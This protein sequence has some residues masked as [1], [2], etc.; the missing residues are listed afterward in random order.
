MLVDIH[1]HSLT[2]DPDVKEV[3]C[4]DP[5]IP[6][7]LSLGGVARFSFGFHPWLVN[8]M[9]DSFYKTQLRTAMQAPGFF[10]LGEVGLDRSRMETWDK[11]L[12]VFKAQLDLV[13]RMRIGRVVVHCVRAFSDMLPLLQELPKSAIIIMHDF[14]GTI[15][16][17]EQFMS[18]L[19]NCYFSFGTKLFNDSTKACKAFS[20]L[21]LERIM[22]ETDDQLDYGI[23]DLYDRACEVRNISLDELKSGILANFL[24]ISGEA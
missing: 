10:A 18:S 1:T 16:T 19:P 24:N 11:Q 22:L 9:E 20:K 2:H 8:E 12:E 7:E 6:V 13:K 15:E 17:A 23:V 4:L 3:V 21:P 14:N 5:T